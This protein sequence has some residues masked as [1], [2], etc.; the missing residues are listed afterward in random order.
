MKE[1]FFISKI[2]TQRQVKNQMK[3]TKDIQIKVRVTET[4]KERIDKY[5]AVNALTVSNFLRMAINEVLNQNLVQ[6]QNN[7]EE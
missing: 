5:C 7:K 2:G 1:I 3:D 4:E 6:Q